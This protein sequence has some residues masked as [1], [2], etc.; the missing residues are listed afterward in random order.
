MG[1][2]D[3][4]PVEARLAE[5]ADAEQADA[6]QADAEAAERRRAKFGA[7]PPRIRSSETVETADTGHAAEEPPEPAV[8]REWG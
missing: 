5:Q 6:E 4:R 3:D 7:L 1:S 8:R 2:I